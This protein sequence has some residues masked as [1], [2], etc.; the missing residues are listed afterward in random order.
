MPMF[1]DG[2]TVSDLKGILDGDGIQDDDK[3]YISTEYGKSGIYSIRRSVPVDMGEDDDMPAE[4]PYI[5][6]NG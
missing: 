2:M 4:D 6:L 3:I 5:I 1:N